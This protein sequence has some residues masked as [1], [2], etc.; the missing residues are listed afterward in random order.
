MKKLLVYL[1]PYTLQVILA[2]LFKF[3]EA[4]FDILVPLVVASVIDVGVK[5][6]D[7]GY[8]INMCLVL[9]LLA[10]VGLICAVVA[11]FFA[12]RAATGFAAKIR[13]V[14]FK[15]I[16]TL[17]YRQIDNLGTPAMITRLT[18]DILNV[19]NGVNLLLRLLLR[20]PFIVLGSVIAAFILDPQTALVLTATVPFLALAVWFVVKFSVPLFKKVQGKS[21]KVLGKVREN[22][23]GVRVIRAFSAEENEQAEFTSENTA[24]ESAQITAGKISTLLNP[25]TYAIINIGVIALLYVGA[26]RI[27]SG[28][29]SQG[30]VIAIYNYTAQILVE[31]VKFANTIIAISK[32]MACGDRLQEVLD[33]PEDIPFPSGKSSNKG[34]IEFDN[35]SLRYKG[36]SEDSLSDLNFVVQKGMTVGVIGGTGSGK[37]SL[38]NMIPRFYG[39]SEGT[40]FVDGNDV[41][42]YNPEELLNKIAVVPQKALLFK[43]TIREN[44]LWGNG[45]ATDEDIEEAIKNAQ[46]TDVIAS[47][48]LGLDEPVEQNGKNFSGG[49]RQRLTIARALVKK[50]EIL[51]LDDSSSALDFATDANLRKAISQIKDTTVF[52]VAQ[53]ASSVMAADMIIVLDDGKAV[54]VGTHD[55]LLKT[56][57]IYREIYL[58]QFPEEEEAAR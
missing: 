14:I 48:T 21:D 55:E 45:S 17:S 44:L 47:K 2:P 30:A 8:I 12:A 35:V 16:N 1:K 20:S 58:S 15:K 51:I 33:I 13:S 3:L 53:R 26:I 28:N 19:Q 57:D 11:Q 38:I 46:A 36:S 49:Q 7:K 54:G 52:I 6:G 23:S 5:N 4:G 42:D 22:I 39:A 25:L 37:T 31:L 50:P 56:C 34:F 27:D 40:V 32:S 24:L 43:G 18:G 29:L 41:N 9:V 10:F